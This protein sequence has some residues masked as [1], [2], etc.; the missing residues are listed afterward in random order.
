M[1]KQQTLPRRLIFHRRLGPIS[2]V[3]SK[4]LNPAEDLKLTVGWGHAGKGGVTMPGK[5]KIVERSY[6]PDERESI[7]R[8]LQRLGISL[9]EVRAHLGERTCDV[10]LNDV[11]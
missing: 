11:A 5:G 2:H 7:G 4:S 1:P 8:S 10:Y 3:E 6:T 9:E